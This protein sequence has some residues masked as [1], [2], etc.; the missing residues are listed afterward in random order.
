VGNGK[1]I[2]VADEADQVRIHTSP[3]P[4]RHEEPY[5]TAVYEDAASN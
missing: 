4:L 1:W 5:F 3:S 2:T